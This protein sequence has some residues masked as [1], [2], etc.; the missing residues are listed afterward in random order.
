MN[1]FKIYHDKYTEAV[2][3]LKLQ[4]ININIPKKTKKQS[5]ITDFLSR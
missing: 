3:G 5:T 1:K 2:S 4:Q